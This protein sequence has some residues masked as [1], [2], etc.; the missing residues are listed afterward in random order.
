MAG[1]IKQT[2]LSIRQKPRLINRLRP[3]KMS[4]RKARFVSHLNFD[5]IM[6]LKPES[7]ETH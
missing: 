3:S 1:D 7:E 6:F 5:K 4:R 2:L